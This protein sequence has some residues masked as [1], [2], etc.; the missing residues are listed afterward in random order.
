MAPSAILIPPAPPSVVDP[1]EQERGELTMKMKGTFVWA[2]SPVVP[3]FIGANGPW[4]PGGKAGP[5]PP[6][7]IC[8]GWER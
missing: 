3:L 4:K 2:L 5:P 7:E 8:P 6:P 1:L